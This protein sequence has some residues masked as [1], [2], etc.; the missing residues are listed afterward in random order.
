M[1][2]ELTPDERKVSDILSSIGA[3]RERR[4]EPI[5]RPGAHRWA[6]ALG[7]AA[8]VAV[9]AT[10]AIVLPRA[11]GDQHAQRPGNAGRT[12]AVSPAPSTPVSAQY[13]G[14]GARLDAGQDQWV[15]G[16]SSLAVTRDGG[17]EWSQLPLPPTVLTNTIYTIAVLPGETVVASS[18][19][20]LVSV[21]VNIALIGSPAWETTV[22]PFGV[23]G[24]VGHLQIV[25]S[26]GTLSGIMMILTTSLNFSQG[27]WLAAPSG[28]SG[29]HASAT[30][31][32]GTVTSVAG[33]LWLVGGVQNQDLYSSS[34]GGSNWTP[35]T[36]PLT[37]GTSVAY[38]PVEA[39]GRGVALVATLS[40]SDEA[41]VVTGISSRAGW[42]WSGGAV[43]HLGGQIGP[44]GRPESS[45]AD[46]VMWILGFSDRVIRVDL[47]TGR[48][49]QVTP[50]G[51]PSLAGNF[52]IAALSK[53]SADVTDLD[54][55]CQHSQASCTSVLA[56][57][58]G[59]LRWTPIA[60]PLR[61]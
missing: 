38:G 46:G 16:K 27:V 32:G 35:I 56:S 1:R 42:Q 30:P 11:L 29:W 37:V 8:I 28:S 4:P 26:D 10:S 31:A 2:D 40:N 24:Q 7:I 52:T 9:I 17:A 45:V 14:A 22:V 53:T 49:A 39:D 36:V 25:D 3:P 59:G 57:T 23:Y 48:V 61:N 55:R 41:Q 60:D 33:E 18:P 50:N 12:P 21:M 20:P 6:A 47:A 15:L 44:G 58:D 51:L 19:D 43:I 13:V 34:D 5:P 54:P